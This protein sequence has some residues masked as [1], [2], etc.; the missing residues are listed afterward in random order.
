MQSSR[1]LSLR[2]VC[3]KSQTTTC[4]SVTKQKKQNQRMRIRSRRWYDR[5]H[6]EL[7]RQ[8]HCQG[9]FFDEK[10]L[11]RASKIQEFVPTIGGREQQQDLSKPGCTCQ[12]HTHFGRKRQAKN[13]NG[14][15]R[16]KTPETVL[17][18][19]DC[20]M[21]QQLLQARAARTNAEQSN[22]QHMW[23]VAE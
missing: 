4:F 17:D 8:R 12:R 15:S 1:I 22:L 21:T 2:H 10:C 13:Q 16:C 11:A 9:L 23:L 18:E 5:K 6:L 14:E 3:H 19:M 7:H 20:V